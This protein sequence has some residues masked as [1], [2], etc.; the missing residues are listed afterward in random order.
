MDKDN[1]NQENNKNKG[2]DNMD[3]LSIF[4]QQNKSKIREVS[5]KNIIRNKKGMIV[6]SK[7]DEWRNE[8]EWD[9]FYK[10]VK[11]KK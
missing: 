9:D 5:E 3:T 10:D 2:E 6:L 7:N 4:I 8:N 1:N 11:S